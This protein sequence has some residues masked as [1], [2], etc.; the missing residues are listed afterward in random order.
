MSDNFVDSAFVKYDRHV[1]SKVVDGVST[2]FTVGDNLGVASCMNA[3]SLLPPKA[4]TP[5]KANRFKPRRGS[6]D[7]KDKSSDNSYMPEGFPDDVCY[8]YNYRSC[9]GKCSKKHSCR[10]CKSDHPAK[11]CQSKKD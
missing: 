9:T 8:S 3:S 4:S 2:T 11:T 10:I 7:S 5:K 6:S 1:V